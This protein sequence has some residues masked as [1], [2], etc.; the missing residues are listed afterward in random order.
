MI[1]GTLHRLLDGL[2]WFGAFPSEL[3]RN[4]FKLVDGFV[5]ELTSLDW[6]YLCWLYWLT[7]LDL[8]SPVHPETGGL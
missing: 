4:V 6:W 2:D 8:L 1:V 7:A 5:P 3:T